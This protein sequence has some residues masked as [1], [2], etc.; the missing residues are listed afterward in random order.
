MAKNQKKFFFNISKELEENLKALSGVPKI[1]AGRRAVGDA[2]H[3]VYKKSARAKA[4]TYTGP[5]RGYYKYGYKGKIRKRGTLQKTIVFSLNRNKSQING[6]FA[7]KD[8]VGHLVEYG[9]ATRKGLIK[10]GLFKGL[11]GK[12]KGLGKDRTSAFPF[13]RP[14]IVENRELAL[15]RMALVLKKFISNPKG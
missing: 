6:I 11:K 5:L 4:R 2:G 9:H 12:G 8:P 10:K 7:V 1:I 3:K 15:D 13:M 14:A